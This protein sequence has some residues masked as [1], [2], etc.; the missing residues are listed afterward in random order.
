MKYIYESIRTYFKNHLYKN[1][2][3]LNSKIQVLIRGLL[4]YESY[5]CNACNSQGK[6]VQQK[7]PVETK[8]NFV[9]RRQKEV[10]NVL[11]AGIT[12]D[13]NGSKSDWNDPGGT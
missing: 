9:S 7:Y 4:L 8:F 5:Q 3:R 10:K 1:L 13:L 2:F 12:G 6:H 11:K